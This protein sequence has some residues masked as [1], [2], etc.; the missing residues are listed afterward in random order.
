[1][2]LDMYQERIMDHYESP[3]HRGTLEAPALECYSH[4]PLCGDEV[5][6]QARLD[7]AG[8]V[9]EAYFEGQGCVISLA[10]A[11]MLMEAVEGKSLEAIKGMT[12]QDML[13]LLGIR[14]TTMRVKCA[15]LPLRTLEKAIHLYEGQ[16]SA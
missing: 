6:I 13:D 12:R 15:M 14:L 16:S 1:M 9:A 5:R 7:E 2:N 3:Y 8:R 4:N 11:S 10:A